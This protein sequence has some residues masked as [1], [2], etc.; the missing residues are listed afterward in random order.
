MMPS[1]PTISDMTVASTG[2]RIDTSGRNTGSGLRVGQRLDRSAVA[3]LELARG[4]HLVLGAEPFGDL[5]HTFAP[6]PHLDPGQRRLAVDHAEH[7]L[8]LALRHERLLGH[9]DGVV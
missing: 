9:L 4:H 5:D 2:R 1:R 7:E 6:D 8:V 3:D